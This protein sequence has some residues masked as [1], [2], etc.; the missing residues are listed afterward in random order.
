MGNLQKAFKKK[1]EAGEWITEMRYPPLGYVFGN[2]SAFFKYEMKFE[3][4]F[5]LNIPQVGSRKYIGGSRGR[6]KVN[7]FKWPVIQGLMK[8]KIS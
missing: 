8:A 2:I 5:N 1:G 7:R 3:L 6:E 4:A